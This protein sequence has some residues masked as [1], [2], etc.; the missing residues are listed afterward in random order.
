[1]INDQFM[2]PKRNRRACYHAFM[3]VSLD[4]CEDHTEHPR[5]PHTTEGEKA[6]TKLLYVMK[7]SSPFICNNPLKEP[8]QHHGPGVPLDGRCVEGITILVSKETRYEMRILQSRPSH[9]QRPFHVKN[10]NIPYIYKMTILLKPGI[11]HIC[12]C[13]E[14]TAISLRPGGRVGNAR[15][16]LPRSGFGIMQTYELQESAS[17][18]IETTYIKMDSLTVDPVRPKA[19]SFEP[20]NPPKYITVLSPPG[21]VP[22]LWLWSKLGRGGKGFLELKTIAASFLLPEYMH[23]QHVRVIRHRKSR[24]FFYNMASYPGCLD[25][26]LNVPPCRTCLFRGGYLLHRTFETPIESNVDRMTSPPTCGYLP[27]DTMQQGYVEPTTDESADE[28]GPD[29]NY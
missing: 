24:N 13:T 12:W 4:D 25:R 17:R 21:E 26:Y 20:N 18:N 10:L 5:R 8:F 22:A 27:E 28:E 3:R 16:L 6:M 19:Y 14:S 2:E 23:N 29:P 9:V 7:A 11:N 1:M 15:L